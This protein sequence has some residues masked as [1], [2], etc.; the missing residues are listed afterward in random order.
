MPWRKLYA[1]R[2]NQVEVRLVLRWRRPMNSG[3]YAF[4]LLRP[5]HR[6]HL[7]M[8]GRNLFRL[9]AHA[10]GHDDFAV[11]LKRR[12]DCGERFRLR[13]IEE[14]AGINDRQVGIGVIA[15]QFVTFRAQPRDN[16]LGIDQRLR[17]AERYERDAGGL[18]TRNSRFAVRVGARASNWDHEPQRSS[19]TRSK[20]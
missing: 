15:G 1:L 8:R 4:V 3:Q 12:P 14:A 13:A 6:Q 2:R 20:S 5:R 16:A 9:R 11:F 18:F 7:R 19:T 10:A 17:A